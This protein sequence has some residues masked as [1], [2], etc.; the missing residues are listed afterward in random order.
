M[1]FSALAK[2]LCIR[3]T[4][5]KLYMLSSSL[6]NN[7]KV[8]FDWCLDKCVWTFG[9][10]CFLFL[11]EIRQEGMLCQKYHYISVII[12]QHFFL[13]SKCKK[14]LYVNSLTSNNLYK[15]ILSQIRHFQNK[16]FLSFAYCTQPHT[17][18]TEVEFLVLSK[19]VFS[20]KFHHSMST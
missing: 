3:T 18:S 13:K 17:C 15:I 10:M 1:K 5:I 2:Q 7:K 14:S 12:R 8:S 11:P 20:T 16:S 6:K 19:I 4:L 9:L